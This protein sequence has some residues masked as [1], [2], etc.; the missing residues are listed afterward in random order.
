MGRPSDFNRIWDLPEDE[1]KKDQEQAYDD[2][3]ESEDEEVKEAY[4]NV[5]KQRRDSFSSEGEPNRIRDENEVDDLF[6]FAGE[7]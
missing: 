1:E 7:I 4:I 2:Q 3:T 5:R 6:N